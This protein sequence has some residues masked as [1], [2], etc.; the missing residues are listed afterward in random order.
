MLL[1]FVVLYLMISVG[2]ALG[3][4]GQY[5]IRDLINGVFI[6]VEGQFGIN[7]IVKI[8]EFAGVVEDVNL[9]T[10]TLRDLEGRQIVIPNGEIKIVTN[11]TRDFAQSLIEIGIGVALDLAHLL[12]RVTLLLQRALQVTQL[13]SQRLQLAQEFD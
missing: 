8:G 2:I 6:L 5:L 10:T 3:F 9:R 12:Q 4:G 13:L 7:D 1:W 11:R